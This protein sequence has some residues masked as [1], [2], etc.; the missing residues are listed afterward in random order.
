MRVLFLGN[1]TVGVRALRV[2]HREAALAG[3]VA[4]PDDP[5][6]GVCYESVFAEATRA[7]VSVLRATGKSPELEAFVRAAA[8]DLLWITDYRYLLPGRLLTLPALGTVN[9]HPSLLPKYRGRAPINWAIIHGE[10]QLGL[11]AH[12]VDEGMDSGDIIAQ[13]AF[14]LGEMQDVGDALNRLYPIYEALTVEVLSAFKLGIVGRRKQDAAMA[15]VFPRRTPADGLIDWSRPARDV[16]NLIRAVARPY[17]G[18]YTQWRERT[19]RIWQA[20]R[21]Q[22]FA[23]GVVPRSG[24]VLGVSTDGR[25]ITVA[26]SD[27]ALVITSFESDNTD[28]LAPRIGD[29]LSPFIQV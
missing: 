26:C 10:T 24:E 23:A 25:N 16:W 28:T 15:T 7:G 17:P 6:D 11:T 2:I 8:P 1:H 14:T 4:H 18:A 19:L 21:V 13:R 3:V 27:E 22:A 20:G 9:L 29:V 5:E 12:F